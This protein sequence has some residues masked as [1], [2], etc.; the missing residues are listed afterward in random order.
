M[1]GVC[2]IQAFLIEHKERKMTDH[3]QSAA[4]TTT[5]V[6]AHVRV[7][8]GHLATAAVAALAVLTLVWALTEE[9]R[10]PE[11]QRSELFAVLAQAYP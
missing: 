4:G 7:D 5:R 2:Q 3:A 8:R 6:P 10:L 11:T 9:A 1:R